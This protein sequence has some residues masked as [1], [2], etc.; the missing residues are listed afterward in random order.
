[1]YANKPEMA[2]KWSAE[3]KRRE[4]RSIEEKRRKT[5]TK[6]TPKRK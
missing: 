3:E 5:K 4:K 2:K 1:M 6:G